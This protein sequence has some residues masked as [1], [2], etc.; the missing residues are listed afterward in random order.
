MGKIKLSVLDIGV[1][2]TNQTVQNAFKTSMDLAS[3]SDN[4]GYERFWVAEHHN[5]KA[6]ITATTALLTGVLAAKTNKISVG[7]YTLLP[8]YTAYMIAEQSATLEACFPDRIDVCIG[9]ATGAD[10]I[11]TKAL[12]GQ[13]SH[14]DKEDPDYYSLLKDYIGF[15]RPEGITFKTKDKSYVLQTLPNIT[16]IPDLWI[17]GGSE[18]EAIIAANLGL[19]FAFPYHVTGDVGVRKIIDIYKNNFKPSL[20]LN[21]PKV[22]VSVIAIVAQTNEEAKRLAQSH[23]YVLAAFRSGELETSQPLV[24][25]IESLTIPNKYLPMIEHYKKTWLIGDVKTVANKL[26]DLA[27]E[28]NVDELMIN[29]LAAAYAAD[30]VEES[31]NRVFTLKSLAAELL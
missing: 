27:K 21:K 15:M 20:F 5:V 13:L 28:F 18:D 4:L 9:G 3:L 12:R 6:A 23:L 19:C 26:K 17:M 14:T 8:H 7:G 29:P 11:A 30:N 25:E 24:E 1:M 16:S 10:W 2:R 22:L 31:K